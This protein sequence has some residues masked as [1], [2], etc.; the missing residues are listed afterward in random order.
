MI[1]KANIEDDTYEPY[2]EDTDLDVTL[3]ALPTMTGT[4]TL[5][6]G[7]EVQP[8]NVYLKGRIKEIT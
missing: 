6:V 7:T 2:I 4:N 1:R 5:T 8:S 3:P